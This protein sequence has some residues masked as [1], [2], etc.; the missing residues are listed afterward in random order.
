MYWFIYYAHVLKLTAP[1]PTHP[2]GIGWTF[3]F[4]ASPN[5]IYCVL[6]I[7]L[8]DTTLTH[9][10]LSTTL[11]HVMDVDKLMDCLDI[12]DNVQEKISN[13]AEDVEQQ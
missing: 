5:L 7:P 13:Y 4:G 1:L 6:S 10:N 12:P 2:H 3:C 9:S 8:T 11:N